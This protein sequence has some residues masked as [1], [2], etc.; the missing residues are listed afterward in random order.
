MMQ[1]YWSIKADYPDTL[2]FYRM[3]DFY[4]LFY[5]DAE[6]ASKL[7]DITL[8]SRNKSDANQILMAGVPAHSVNHYIAKLVNQSIPVAICD[9]VGDPKTSK[10]PVE[11]KVTRVLTPGTLTDDSLLDAR[12]ENLLAAVQ[13]RRDA[14]AIAQL[15]LSSGRFSAR[16]LSDS[17]SVESELARIGAAEILVADNDDIDIGGA[18]IQQ[19][20]DW[21]FSY[22]RAAQILKSQFRV[23][24]VSVFDGDRYP[25]ATSVAGALLQYAKDVYAS[26][27]P[28]IR[29]LRIEKPEYYLILDHHSWRNLEI[30][31]TLGGESKGA[32]LSLF[33]QCATAMGA[34][35]L[36]RWFRN[37]VRNRDEIE[38]RH[39]IIGHFCDSALHQRAKAGLRE[40]SDL[41]RIVSRIA[42]KSATPIDLAALRNSLEALPE[43]MSAIVPDNCGAL[44]ELC[45]MIDPLPDTSD[46][47]RRSIRDEPAAGLRD[48]GVI[49][50][51]YDAELDEL[52]RLRDG[53]DAALSQMEAREQERTGIRNLRILYNRVYGYSIEVSRL[54]A[55]QVPQDYIRRQTLKNKERYATAEL[56]EFESRILSARERAVAK[57]RALFDEL[58]E[59]LLAQVPG[60]QQTAQALAQIDVLSNFAERASSLILNR[61]TLTEK[62]GIFIEDGR[63]PVVE[64]VPNQQ[65]VPNSA[66]LPHERRLM[67]ITGPNMGGKSTY[68]RQTAL[69]AYLAHVG[70]YVP[71][72]EATIG[73]L[74][75]I[76]TRIGASD[77]LASGRSTFMVEM[78]EMATILHAATDSSLVLVDEIG[79]GTSTFDG[80]ALAWACAVNLARKV[81]A[82]TL[83]S[84]HYFELTALADIIPGTRNVHLDAVEYD[85]DIVFLY[86]V[87]EGA[88]RQ[89]YGLQV[90]R[91]AGVPE[92]VIRDAMVKLD[93]L[94]QSADARQSVAKPRP[95][96]LSLF[97]Q[98]D[99]A[100]SR[101]AEKLNKA[102][103]DEM[104]PREALDFIYELKALGDQG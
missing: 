62:P 84:T 30:E 82:Y 25:A 6:K 23:P 92:D 76:F 95:L 66:R 60:I 18:R 17:E 83:F 32:L 3:G 42:T 50:E 64:S 63:H 37:P 19:V 88:A 87:K 99:A 10:G 96:Q 81:Q 67:M 91:L 45:A 103:P 68:M 26:D 78:T 12:S 73:P 36:R 33:D 40:I 44:A 94:T 39:Q 31:S 4:E 15:E 90:A 77:D 79:R 24:D 29:S 53:S 65:F 16:V 28:H 8:T 34:R 89:S 5:E 55:D 47:I 7:L 2:L 52:I 59:Q 46:L 35:Q 72:K 70:S 48:G 86:E 38:R 71:A 21:Y 43:L 1:Q 100:D 74:D 80:L 98:P 101:V 11:R 54:A 22:E 85:G 102:Q 41:E 56:R 57:E 13:T 9:Q 20:P 61:P 27:F 69:I 51:G 97:S 104:T 58:L 75:R 49:R 14:R 93:E